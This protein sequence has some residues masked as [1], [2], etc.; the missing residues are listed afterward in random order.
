MYLNLV[1]CMIM[2]FLLYTFIFMQFS[3]IVTNLPYG[4]VTEVLFSKDVPCTDNMSASY[5]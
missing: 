5:D 3:I 1:N 2:R 4:V